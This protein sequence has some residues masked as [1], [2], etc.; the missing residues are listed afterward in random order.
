MTTDVLKHL[1]D[2]QMLPTG[3]VVI[4]AGASYGDF[5]TALLQ[6]P[7]PSGIRIFGIE[8]NRT[9]VDVLRAKSI[10]NFTLVDAALVGN[11][12][13]DTMIF[14]EI[15]AKNNKL[16]EWGNLFRLNKEVAKGRSDFIRFDEYA[17][18]CVQI[19]R[20]LE[21]FGIDKIDFLKMDIE[22]AEV[23][24]FNTMPHDVAACIR[25]ASVEHHD[26]R[27]QLIKAI[28]NAGFQV[29]DENQYDLYIVRV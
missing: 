28:E 3:A 23:D 18:R 29:V 25:Q 8:C 10:P 27:K 7:V 14:T 16:H 21:E 1:I 24:I 19:G 13:P 12:S 17:V 4:D 26:N 9:N 2:L 20:I 6:H 5:T 11:T 22:G 15:V